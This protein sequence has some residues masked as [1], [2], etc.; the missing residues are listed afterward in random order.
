MTLPSC[1]QEY[2]EEE[3]IVLK[4]ESLSK[5]KPRLLVASV[6]EEL[7]PCFHMLFCVCVQVLC[8]RFEWLLPS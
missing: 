3:G 8:V 2:I 7:A 5:K 1:H 6:P 4:R